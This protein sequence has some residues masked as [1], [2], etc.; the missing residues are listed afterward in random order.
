M[1]TCSEIMDS[2]RRCG[3][4]AT[5]VTFGVDTRDGPGSKWNATAWNVCDVC[6]KWENT[7]RGVPSCAA[8]PDLA[9]RF[10]PSLSSGEVHK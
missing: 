10:A 5:M 9:R 7:V 4:P 2:G 6:A 3:L 1:L 8:P